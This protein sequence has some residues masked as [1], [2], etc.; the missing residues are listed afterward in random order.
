MA[1]GVAGSLSLEI[2]GNTLTGS[3][4]LG[5]P[6]VADRF[7]IVKQDGYVRPSESYCQ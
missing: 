5:G 7:Q 4:I 2:Q 3:L 6:R 1:S